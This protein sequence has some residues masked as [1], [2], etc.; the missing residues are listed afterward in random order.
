VDGSLL[1]SANTAGYGGLLQNNNGEF[2]WGF[3]GVATI[4]SILFAEIWLFFM[5]YNFVGIVG[6]GK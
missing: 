3:Y 6:T 4:Q 1:D 5:D 2:L